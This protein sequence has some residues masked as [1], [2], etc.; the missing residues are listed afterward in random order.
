[1]GSH[2]TGWENAASCSFSCLDTGK[3]WGHL[4]MVLLSNGAA[5]R[6]RGFKML[7]EKQKVAIL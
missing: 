6:D 5:Q 4:A 3:P 1:M 7:G 2:K